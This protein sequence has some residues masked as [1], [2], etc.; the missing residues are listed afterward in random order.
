LYQILSFSW[1][2][3]P[4]FK[5]IIIQP[6]NLLY[7]SK[8]PNSVIKLSDFGLAKFFNQQLMTT[9]C[10]TPGYV[11]PELLAGKGYDSSI[12]NWALGVIIYIL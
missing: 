6:E 7:A 5:S 10:G 1:N 4:R 11:A 2:S 3:P 8:D 9:G 12:D